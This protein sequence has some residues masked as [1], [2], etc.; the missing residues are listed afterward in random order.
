MCAQT[1][2]IDLGYMEFRMNNKPMERFSQLAGSQLS[3]KRGAA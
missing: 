2:K 3:L 1:S